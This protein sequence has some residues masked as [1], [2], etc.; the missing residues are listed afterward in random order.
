MARGRLWMGFGVGSGRRV[1]GIAEFLNIRLMPVEQLSDSRFF[2]M[3]LMNRPSRENWT[4]T[5]PGFSQSA[6]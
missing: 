4:L 5:R 3:G 6:G 2:T 1:G